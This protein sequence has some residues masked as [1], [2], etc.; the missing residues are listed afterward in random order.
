MAGEGVDE[1]FEGIAGT[2]LACGGHVEGAFE[3]EFCG[4]GASGWGVDAV[5]DAERFGWVED[6]GA[7]LGDGGVPCGGGASF[8]FCGVASGGGE[9]GGCGGEFGVVVGGDTFEP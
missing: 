3:V 4:G 6:S 9:G 7:E 8:W 2:F 1:G 5:D